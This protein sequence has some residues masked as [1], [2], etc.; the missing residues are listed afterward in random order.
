MNVLVIG[1]IGLMGWHAVLELCQRGHRVKILASRPP[2]G[3]ALPNQ[4]TFVK[5]DYL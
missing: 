4:V 5:G 1:G 2:K 3:V